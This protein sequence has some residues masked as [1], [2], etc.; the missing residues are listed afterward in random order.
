[1][2]ESNVFSSPRE[3]KCKYCGK[4]LMEEPSLSMVQIITDENNKI[5]KVNPCCKGNCDKQLVK[6]L[7]SNESDG[8]KEFSEFINPYLHIKHFMS[9]MNSM[10]EG[11]GFE[12]EQA[13]SDYKDFII[14]CYP[15]ITRNLSED[16]IQSASFSEMLPF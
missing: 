6:E 2:Q 7:K 11:I 15:Y 3:I 16:E 1:M 12:N 9:V 13:F 5:T 14:D 8:W 4:N 10:Y